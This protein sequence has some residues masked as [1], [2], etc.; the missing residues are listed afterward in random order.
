MPELVSALAFR[1]FGTLLL[2]AESVLV[3]ASLAVLLYLTPS[4]LAFA[5]KAAFYS[6]VYIGIYGFIGLFAA[7]IPG[8]IIGISGTA[9]LLTLLILFCRGYVGISIRYLNWLHHK[10][11]LAKEDIAL[12]N[13]FA[14]SSTLNHHP[15]QCPLEK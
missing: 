6:V 8:L 5:G 7:I 4:I 10:Y 2:A 9:V 14:S 12:N 15:K 11:Y 3:L 13:L 1:L